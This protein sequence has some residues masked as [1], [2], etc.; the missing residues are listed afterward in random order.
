MPGRGKGMIAT[1]RIRRW[2][3]ALVDF[4][5]MVT[6]NEYTEVSR[7]SEIRRLLERG[8]EQL[9]ETQKE[10]VLS[11]AFRG[12]GELIQDIL[13]TNVFGGITLGDVPHIALYPVGSVGGS[14]G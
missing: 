5:A 7:P 12:Q 3:V 10:R 13:R 6:L 14:A 11:L 4:P 1:R 8:V 9:P 2:E